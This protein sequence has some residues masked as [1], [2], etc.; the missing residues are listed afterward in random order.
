MNLRKKLIRLAHANPELRAD[1]LPLLKTA[2][3]PDPRG[4]GW[5]EKAGPR[6]NRW[7]WAGQDGDPAF[8]VTEHSAP[9][10]SYYKLQILLPDGSMYVTHGQKDNPEHWFKR[11]ADLYKESQT[12]LF[13]L[14]RTPERWSKMASRKQ[15]HGPIGIK[16]PDVML[17]MINPGANNSKFY[18]MKITPRSGRFLLEK[19]WGRLTDDPRARKPGA[20][21]EMFSTQYEAE[22][23]MQAH[24]TSKTRKGYKPAPRNE[25][26][27]G[28]GAA[29]FG[30]GGQAACEYIPELNQMRL[31][32]VTMNAAMK[33]FSE[34]VS[35]LKRQKSS[36]VP[37]L[38]THVRKLQIPLTDLHDY[39]DSQLKECR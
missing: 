31:K 9:F 6:G 7:N 35:D 36:M 37:A 3:G 20:K 5:R 23:A 25:Y 10:G 38:T 28:L 1:I 12:L 8:T 4:R 13:D 33:S 26:P 21:D 19:R 29:G 16:D 17:Y 22:A 39:L 2:R 32:L 34:I 11:A 18:E 24:A 15:A 30:W 27:I 14:S